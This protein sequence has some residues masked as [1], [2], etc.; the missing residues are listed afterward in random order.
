VASLNFDVFGR[1]VLVARRHEWA[2]AR[3]P[4]V[5]RVSQ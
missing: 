2:T 1:K 4:N 3:N 5:V